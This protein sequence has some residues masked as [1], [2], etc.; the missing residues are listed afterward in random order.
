MIFRAYADAIILN[1]NVQQVVQVCCTDDYARRFFAIFDG[2]IQQ[3]EENVGEVKL[4]GVNFRVVRV[5]LQ[6]DV[7]VGRIFTIEMFFTASWMIS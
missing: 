5:E 6:F 2:I 4:V 3:V 7:A 1:T